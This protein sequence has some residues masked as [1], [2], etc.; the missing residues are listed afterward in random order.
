MT[1]LHIHE[2]GR[3]TGQP[4]QLAESENQRGFADTAGSCQED[5]CPVAKFALEAS[6]IPRAVKKVV[7]FDGGSQ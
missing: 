2:D 7:M 1:A 5:V 6:K 4:L 3:A